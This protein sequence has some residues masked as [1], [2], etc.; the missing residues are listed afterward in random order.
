MESIT[1]D[2]AKN[3][4]DKHCI[5]T[6]LGVHN[7][8]YTYN[9]KL[10]AILSFNI[11]NN[12]NIIIKQCETAIN[13]SISGLIT[14]ITTEFGSNANILIDL[15]FGTGDYRSFLNQGFKMIDILKP[16]EYY[17]NIYKHLVLP[18]EVIDKVNKDELKDLGI[19]K[20]Y[21]AGK[22][23]LMWDKKGGK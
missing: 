7:F 13:T 17:I 22:I 4:V 2:E 21:D 5:N 11:D 6:E 18:K 9:N 20:V 16:K 3:F 8:G 23:R 14:S 19:Y 1:L 12:N 15:D 10:V